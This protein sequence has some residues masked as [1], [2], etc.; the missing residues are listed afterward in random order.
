MSIRGYRNGGQTNKETDRLDCRRAGPYAG[1]PVGSGAGSECRWTAG[2]RRRG[3]FGIAS[4]GI[5]NVEC[6]QLPQKLIAKQP[7]IQIRRDRQNIPHAEVHRQFVWPDICR[8]DLSPCGA[9]IFVPRL[10]LIVFRGRRA[11]EKSKDG[12]SD[13]ECTAT[14]YQQGANI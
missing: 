8:A 3:T 13:H 14:Y 4:H 10:P 1:G 7:C 5:A 6:R 2:V 12:T 11:N 9:H